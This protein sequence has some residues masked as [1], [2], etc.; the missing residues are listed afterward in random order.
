MIRSGV[1]VFDYGCGHGDD[2]RYLRE[3]DVSASGWDPHYRPEDPVAAADVVN[4]GYVLNVIENPAER[5]DVL[6]KALSL[7][8]RVLVAAVRVDRGPLSGEAFEDGRVTSRG[9][10]QKVYTQAEFRAYIE[11]VC[12]FKPAMAGLGVAYVFK[13]TALEREY[14]ARASIGRPLFGRRFTIADFESSELGAEYLSLARKL[15]RLPRPSEFPRF[16]AL[17]ERFGS[18]QRIRRLASAVLDPAAFESIRRQKR[19]D[20]LIYYGAMRLQGLRVPRAS[21]LPVE[22]QAD[23]RSVWPSYRAARAEGE[24]FL[25]SMGDPEQ[26]V[27]AVKAAPVGKL[28]VGALYAHRSAEEQLSALNRLQLFAARQIVGDPEYDVLKLSADGQKVSFLRYPGFDEDAHPGLQSSLVVYLPKADYS[29]RD[30][31][32]SENPPILHRKDALVDETYPLHQKFAFLTRQEEKRS[33]LSRPDI[34]RKGDW[35]R[36]LRQAGLEVRGHRLFRRKPQ[37][38]PDTAKPAPE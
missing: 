24:R 35:E 4:L 33:L 5:T 20:F 16:A 38:Q 3:H 10:F 23:I 26:T 21:L 29:F 28:V 2:I 7:A 17:G 18:P 36:V 27:S 37:R 31:S 22:T 30:F 25:F 9:G 14:L 11:S 6:R 19:E 12:S 15:A 13:D 8:R 34:G 1:S 32:R